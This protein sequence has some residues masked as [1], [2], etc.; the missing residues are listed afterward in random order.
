V[1]L[2]GFGGAATAAYS[3]IL[4]RYGLRGVLDIT[5]PWRLLFF[6]LSAAGCLASGYRSSLTFFGLILICL[7]WMEGLWRTRLLPIAAAAALVGAG[8]LLT[9][10]QKLPI[11]G[12]RSMSF[13][14]IEVDPM[15]KESAKAS[16]D[17][18]V[19]VWKV[20]LPQVPQYLLKGKGYSADANDLVME[21]ASASRGFS[22]ASSEAT[23]AVDY[24]N[25]P[26][27]VIVPL[28]LAGMIAFVWFLA[29][30]FSV[31]LDSEETVGS[32]RGPTRMAL[33]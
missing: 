16:N 2:G 4:A 32:D 19:Q 31:G 22:A 7:F 8:L 13:L 15:V 23:V 29:Y 14:P 24:H 20:V 30:W 28:G 27:S 12:Q 21:E 1:R 3:M 9:Q 10:S 11:V 25:G 17:W 5:S 26:L 18:R 6:L 33:G